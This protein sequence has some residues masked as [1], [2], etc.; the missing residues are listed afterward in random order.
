MSLTADNPDIQEFLAAW[1]ET[2]RARFER[3]HSALIYD[4]YAP[5]RAIQRRRFIA[6]NRVTGGRY[7]VERQ[8]GVVY[9][10]RAYGVANRPLGS[11]VALAAAYRRATASG[12]E[13]AEPGYVGADHALR[14]AAMAEEGA[15]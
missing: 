4:E 3:D 9:S 15:R 1:H 14:A 11:L 13:L 5:K 12:I 6:L 2:G 8:T 10:I 7:L